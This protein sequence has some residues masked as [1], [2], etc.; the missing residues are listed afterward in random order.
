MT[1]LLNIKD[2]GKI[3]DLEKT[4]FIPSIQTTEKIIRERLNKN[5]IYLGIEIEE[6]LVGTLALRFAHFVPEFMDF[7][8]RNPT[9]YDYAERENE[10]NANS[11]FVYSIGI[12]PKY[13]NG[14]NAKKLLLGAF[15]I[16]K[17]RKLD[18]LVGDARIPTYNGSDKNLRYEQFDKN[19]NLHLAVDEY[20]KTGVLPSRE[21]IEQDPVAGF[22]LKLFP[23]GKILGI[24]NE[25]F[26]KGDKPCGGHMI[27][28][29]LRLEI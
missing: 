23:Q 21:L 7:C 5:H 11:V 1:N 2:I 28:E 25:N 26:W 9:F 22:Y 19:G 24:T 4:A 3:L 14:I 12:N 17:Q 20:F 27:I 18:F 15:N 29:F 16:A 13:R 10:K 6:K 8:K